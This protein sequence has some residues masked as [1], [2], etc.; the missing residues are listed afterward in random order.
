MATLKKLNNKWQAQVRMRGVR[1]AR[2]FT[3]K[4]L[5][6]SWASKVE[7]EI[8]NGTYQ[9]NNELLRMS[10]KALMELYFDHKRHSTDHGSRLKDEVNKLSRYPI[11]SIRLG[12][13]NG[14][15]VASFRDQLL[16]EGLA[17]STTRKYLGL[18]QRAID[19][20]RKELGIPINHN[21]VM[22]VSKP[23]EDDSRD[24]V[25]EEHEWERLLE[26]CSKSSVHFLKQLV[27][28]ARETTCRRSEILRI[29]RYDINFEKG[30][31]HIPKTK[32]GSP[33]TI[34][35]SPRAM[36]VL[37]SI[38]ISVDGSYFKSPFK[39]IDNLGN[40]ISK[41]FAR[42][43]KNANIKDFRLHDVRHMSA[44]DRAMQGWSIAELS[45]QGGWK[46][47]SQLKRY[48]HVKGEHLAQKLRQ[49]G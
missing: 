7:T 30:T 49:D 44:S 6:S 35:L 40:V 25:L 10:V 32:N 20:G 41:A 31:L 23:R 33:R 13:L 14:K 1:K 8:I 34:G 12:Y 36:E 46:S 19:I 22:L 38:P 29:T 9:D 16:S 28:L 43:V 11:G 2:S 47:L 26:E 18:L 39:S 17:K 21:P 5:A 48:T 27:I 3:K 37:K 45:A 4:Q 24:R 15:H 42:A